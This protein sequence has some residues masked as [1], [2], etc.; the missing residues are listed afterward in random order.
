MRA[1]CGGALVR[2]WHALTGGAS[3][4][5][6]AASG[7]RHIGVMDAADPI[8]Q[9]AGLGRIV[10][11]WAH[12]DD[13]SYLVGGLMAIARWL[14][15]PV[16]CVTAT[17]GDFADTEH[18]RRLA[19]RRRRRELDAA[20]DVLGVHDRV[21]LDL[22][23]G[24]CHAAD[25]DRVIATL[26]G[27]I[28]DRKPDTVITFG[29]DGWT[30]HHDHRA[31]SAWTTAAVTL[32]APHASVLFPAVTP[33]INAR[34]SAINERFSVFDPGLPQ[35]HDEHELALA[36]HLDG[37]WLD[38][39]LAALRAHASQTDPLIDAVGRAQYRA[40]IANECFIPAPKRRVSRARSG[41]RTGRRGVR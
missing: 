38:R 33:E 34:E 28:A 10:T 13:E 6:R 8:E 12:P 20:L 29:P 26:A 41:G 37:P 21:L 40:Y 23:D 7:D 36:L 2:H 19:G 9:V 16:T 14:G 27:V 22:G 15:Q 11:V 17:N 24:R 5:E 30:G 31:V 35:L 18:A 32:A 25:H 39:K 3:A 1:S 4:R